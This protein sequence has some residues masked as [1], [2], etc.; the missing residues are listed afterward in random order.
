MKHIHTYAYTRVHK[1]K[2]IKS[3]SC[4]HIQIYT[5]T[6]LQLHM[7]TSTNK[8]CT[9]THLQTQTLTFYE[10]VYNPRCGIA[11]LIARLLLSPVTPIVIFLS[12]QANKQLRRKQY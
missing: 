7:H 3:T 12:L 2:Y 10:I 1:R 5:D 4:T 8:K 6:H 11:D 9:R